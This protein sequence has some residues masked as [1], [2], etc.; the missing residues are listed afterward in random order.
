MTENE[1]TEYEVMEDE[2]TE[3]EVMEDEVTKTEAMEAE[4]K[5]LMRSL[6][7]LQ[8][9]QR[10][11]QTIQ[12]ALYPTQEDIKIA[13]AIAEAEAWFGRGSAFPDLTPYLPLQCTPSAPLNT[14]PD[15]PLMHLTMYPVAPPVHPQFITG[16]PAPSENA[17]LLPKRE[18]PRHA[19]LPDGTYRCN[20]CGHVAETRN[21]IKSHY[22]RKHRGL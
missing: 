13:K 4:A 17:P 9:M 20:L 2:V 18:S 21:S 15:A 6:P 1:V 8:T 10:D 3:Y 16:Q 11:L 12:R 5:K 22:R 14:P 7:L 19:R